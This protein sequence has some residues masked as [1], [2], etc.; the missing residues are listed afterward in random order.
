M[1][2]AASA[3]SVIEI[4][5]VNELL[6]LIVPMMLYSKK[7][8]APRDDRSQ[9]VSDLTIEEKI[10]HLHSTRHCR[11]E[12]QAKDDRHQQNV[13][14]VCCSDNGLFFTSKSVKCQC[15]VGR[16]FCT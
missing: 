2:G 7:Q 11:S 3:L 5:A 9:H 8:L 15:S 13:A 6:H 1:N 4:T 16:D 14:S 10:E 12:F